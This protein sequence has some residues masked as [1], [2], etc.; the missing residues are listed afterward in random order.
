MY[1]TPPAWKRILA[2]AH[3]LPPQEDQFLVKRLIG[4]PG[5][6]VVCCDAQSRITV[7]GYA[8]DESEYTVYTN[9]L[10]AFKPFDFIVPEGRIFVMGDHRD[11]SSDSRAHMCQG[12][13]TPEK[14]FPK[15]ESIQG[16][17]FA[18]MTPFSRARTFTVPAVFANIPPSTTPAPSPD[19]VQWSCG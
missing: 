1:E 4:L 19:T 14:A 18:I 16:R 7:N 2:W 9:P 3:V 6:H 15:I 8:L 5:D 12:V 13:P 10:A 11:R 17:T